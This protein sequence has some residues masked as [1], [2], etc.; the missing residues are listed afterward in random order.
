M[1]PNLL[2]TSLT[3]DLFPSPWTHFQP[4]K[5]APPEYM[6]PYCSSHPRERPRARENGADRGLDS[7]DACP[8]S[9]TPFPASPSPITLHSTAKEPKL[10]APSRPPRLPLHRRPPGRTRCR[11][12]LSCARRHI[13]HVPY[14]THHTEDFTF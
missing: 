12:S 9:P 1:T 13:F 11:S 6:M 14:S 8:S 5:L 4:D 10:R 2:P 3:P 7:T